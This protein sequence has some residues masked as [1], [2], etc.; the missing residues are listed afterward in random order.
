[1]KSVRLLVLG[2]ALVAAA[3]VEAASKCR[4]IEA[5]RITQM[6]DHYRKQPTA[7]A[8]SISGDFQCLSIER[9]YQVVCRTRTTHYAHPSIVIRTVFQSGNGIQVRTEAD[10]AADCGSFVRLVDE[11][12]QLTKDT[13]GGL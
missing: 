1:M 12:N 9:T 8:M 5:A 2:A 13:L 4:P 11:Y 7:A 6:W 3:P 10:T